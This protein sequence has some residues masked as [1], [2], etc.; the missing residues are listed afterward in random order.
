MKRFYKVGAHKVN[1]ITKPMVMASDVSE[2]CG[3]SKWEEKTI[4]TRTTT[5]K[6]PYDLPSYLV[7]FFHEFFHMIDTMQGTA[8]FNDTDSQEAE[9]KETLLDS[10]CE[11]FVQFMLE[12][13]MLRPSWIKGCKELLKKTKPIEV[14]EKKNDL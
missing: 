10:F 2:V 11:G 7:I 3:I 5:G 9:M 12:N 4:E 14:E 13:N 1:L 8:L 6:V